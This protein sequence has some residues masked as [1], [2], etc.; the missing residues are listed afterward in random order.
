LSSR[1]SQQRQSFIAARTGWDTRRHLRSDPANTPNT[2]PDNAPT[3]GPI[4]GEPSPTNEVAALAMRLATMVMDYFSE[5][6]VLS[7]SDL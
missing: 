7:L 5:T 3:I 6:M 1:P 2:T 4:T